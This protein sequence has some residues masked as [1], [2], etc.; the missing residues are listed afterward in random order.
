[1]LIDGNVPIPESVQ[2]ADVLIV[3]AGAVGLVLGIL[4]G[5]AGWRV[6]IVE[7]GGQTPS[8]DYITANWGPSTGMHH[9]GLL[10][11]RMKALGGTTR[12]WGGQLLPFGRSDF[13]RSYVGKPDWPI[14]YDDIAPWFSR[15]FA[16]LDIPPEDLDENL[17]WASTGNRAPDLGPHL[18]VG[19]SIWLSAFLETILKIDK[20]D[21]VEAI[22][23]AF[24]GTY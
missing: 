23:T 22:T 16:F 3:G 12:L 6:T 13:Q 14:Q 8:A 11:G 15:A 10:D 5:R 1:M 20:Q 7:A 18:R 2:S 21:A 9:N 17:I 19:M 4:L 24:R